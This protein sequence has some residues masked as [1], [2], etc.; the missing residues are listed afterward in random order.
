M[1]PLLIPGTPRIVIV[2][3]VILLLLFVMYMFT[4]VLQGYNDARGYSDEE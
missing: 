4:K 3:I 1:Q 2:G